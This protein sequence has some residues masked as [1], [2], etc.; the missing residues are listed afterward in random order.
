MQNVIRKHYL[1][2]T[3]AM[4]MRIAGHAARHNPGKRFGVFQIFGQW[5]VSTAYGGFICSMIVESF[6]EATD[7]LLVH[8]CDSSDLGV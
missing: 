3:E 1:F 7:G 6:T 5:A 4:A 2:P 8:P